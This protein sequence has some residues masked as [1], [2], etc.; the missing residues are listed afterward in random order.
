MRV[1]LLTHSYSPE[2]SP[3]QRRWTQII[4][5]F[6]QQDWDV[7]VVAPV[8]HA[9]HGRR[10]LPKSDAG[11][12]FRRDTGVFGEHVRRVP[13][14]WHRTTRLGRLAD[15]LVSAACSVPAAL[16]GPKP[17]VV[18]VTVPSLPILGAGYLAARLLRKPLVV[19]MR[20]AWPDIARDARL[21][22]G[23]AKGLAERVIVAIQDRA[24]LVVTV[25]Y[26]FAQTLRDRG[27]GNVATVSNGVDVSVRELLRPPPEEAEF[28][29]V[30][31]LGNHGESQRLDV[32]IRAAALA[33]D[34]VRLHLVGHGV[35]R[36]EL[37][38]LARE[39][40]APVVFHD[41]AVGAEVMEHY[42][43]ADTCVVSLRD[44]WKS[45]ETTIPSKT[46]EVLAVGRHVTGIVLGEAR[47]IIEE[48]GAGDVVS[49]HPE[50]V[51]QLWRALAADRSMLL[52]GTSG[53]DWIN[54]NANVD[55]LAEAYAGLLTTLVNGVTAP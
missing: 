29:S 52:T 34:C 49:A 32:V 5:S 47:K 10:T 53:R 12:A 51:A 38:A 43:Q 33:R 28:L 40:D 6:R 50:K 24:D 27:L 21:V 7:D 15:H 55:A 2:H 14:L 39:L 16:L 37:M 20:D 13:Y 17:D 19:D 11:R 54:D 25:T 22:P 42:R 26:G 30:L 3:P 36:R 23:S 45:F 9:P 4:R 46:Y 48:A 18:I 1:L 41:P 44:D 8:A 31:Y 35:Q